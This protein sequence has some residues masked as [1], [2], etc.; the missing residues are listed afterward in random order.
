MAKRT[1]I[2][3]ELK[4]L[5]GYLKAIGE[6]GTKET[7]TEKATGQLPY[8][9]RVVSHKGRKTS[10]TQLIL[11]LIEKS[12]KGIS[13]DEIMKQTG[14]MRNTVNGVLNRMKEMGKV[15]AASRGVYVKQSSGDQKNKADS[16]AKPRTKA[17]VKPKLKSPGKRTKGAK[18]VSAANH[19]TVV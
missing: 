6:T 13:I 3:T 1:E 19:R 9:K 8:E 2:E 10:A 18:K 14:L 5:E 11:S 15:K 16:A 17:P 7:G 4:G 12:E